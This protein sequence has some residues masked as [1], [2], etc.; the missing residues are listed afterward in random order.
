MPRQVEFHQ[1]ERINFLYHDKG[2][3][4]KQIEIALKEEFGENAASRPTIVRELRK[5]R[6]RPVSEKWQRRI[7]AYFFLK[8][9]GLTLEE[10][11][12]LCEGTIADVEKEK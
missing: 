3:G 4:P 9:K 11:K 1:K 7:S 2:L 10:I 5:I 8:Q 6:E 12:F